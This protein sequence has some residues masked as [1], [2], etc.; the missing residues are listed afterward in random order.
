MTN[1]ATVY[2]PGKPV[3]AQNYW[4]VTFVVVFVL[5]L[6]GGGRGGGLSRSCR[7]TF[8]RKKTIINSCFGQNKKLL[9]TNVPIFQH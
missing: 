3:K 6:G 9:N 1:V 4:S 5:F 2:S 8:H 7:T